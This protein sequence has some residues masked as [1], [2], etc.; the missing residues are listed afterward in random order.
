[1]TRLTRAVVLGGG[2]TGML[3]A[4]ALTR[5][6]AS[7]TVVERDVLPDGPLHRK[8]LPQARHVH[9]LW[10]SGAR[11]VEGYLPHT[12]E[13]LLAAGARYVGFHDDLVTLTASGWQHRFPATQFAVMCSRPLLDWVVRDQILAGGQIDLRQETEAV[14]LIGD[15]GRVTGVKVR[16][17]I[18][19]A[20]TTLEADLVLDATGRGSRIRQWLSGLGVPAIEEDIVD[21]GVA[22]ATRLYRAPEGADGFPA[23]NVAAD[24][25]T[26]Q[27][28]R[29]GVV[30]PIEDDQWMVTLTGTRGATMPTTEED[31]VAFARQLR[32]PIVADLIG[33][34]EPLSPVSGS[35]AALNRRLYPER[36]E[37]WPDG[38][39]ILGD[40]LAAFNPVYGH[41]MSAAARSIAALDERLQRG[42]FGP[43]ET[44][45]VQRALGEAVDDPWIMAALKDIAYVNCR[46]LSRDPRLTGPD[47]A[48]RLKFS[49]FISG[50][51]VRSPRVCEV[52]TGVLSLSTSQSEMGSPQFL[53]LLHKD[54]MYPALAGPPFR[55]GELEMVGL[56]TRTA[57]A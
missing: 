7:V 4:Q 49:D 44:R 16:D 48:A 25:L 56:A 3:V 42:G 17:T 39:L 23:V 5:H 18:G 54:T 53:S 55:P 10:S 33:V 41:G 35:H 13:R 32:H 43:G 8:G 27:S 29:F 51:S 11:I 2:W 50:K 24:H 28:G 22:Y 40:S 52:V 47:T 26:R 30:Y 1:M 36:L 46:N 9:V 15:R 14:D 19:G 57:R 20:V 45:A 37:R 6:A 31:F 12:K 38:L 21:A 34:A